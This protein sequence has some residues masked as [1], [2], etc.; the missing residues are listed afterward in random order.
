MNSGYTLITG[1]SNGI[2]KALAEG[3]AERGMNLL[4]VS[5]AKTGLPD[6]GDSIRSH[7]GV[8]VKVYEADLTVKAQID[9]LYNYIIAHNIRLSALVNNAGVGYEA[10]FD[11]LTPE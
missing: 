3:C 7:Y 11:S 5:L 9:G 8:D 2:G 1:A 4:L 6:V 10:S